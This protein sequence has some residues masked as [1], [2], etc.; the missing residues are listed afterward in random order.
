M[1][2]LHNLYQVLCFSLGLLQTAYLLVM[3]M[4]Q[5]VSLVMDCYLVALYHMYDTDSF[6]GLLY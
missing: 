2:W 3:T 5:I 4:A 1:V 6:L